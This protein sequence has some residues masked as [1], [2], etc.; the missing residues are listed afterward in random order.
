MG[1]PG[2]LPSMGLQRVRHDWS[3]LAAADSSPPGSSVHGILQARILVWVAI[4]FSR[5]SSWPRDRTCISCIAGGF[6]TAEPPGKPHQEKKD[7][8]IY[9]KFYTNI[10]VTTN[11]KSRRE[12]QKIK[13][14]TLR[15][16]SNQNS[17]QKH[18]EKKKNS[19]EIE[20]PENKIVVLSLHLSIITLNVNGLNSPVK[21]HGVVGWIKKQDSTTCCLQAT[22]ISSTDKHRFKAKEQR[23]K[24]L[25]NDGQKGC[26][27]ILI[28]S[29]TDLKTKM[30]SILLWGGK[31]IK[32]T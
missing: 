29:R 8:F 10:T 23:M 18:K 15:K 22:H 2:G 6:F 30:D 25:A 19:R 17:R 27:A 12:R 28:P 31:V 14:R 32:K 9:E 16:P 26:V 20:Q 5:G 3:G 7:Y 1:R 4:S 11:H 13:K 21:K 24:L